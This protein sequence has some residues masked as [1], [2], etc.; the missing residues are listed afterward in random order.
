MSLRR[1]AAPTTGGR[2]TLAAFA[3]GAEA[4]RDRSG[5]GGV[6]RREVELGEV[7]EGGAMVRVVRERGVVVLLGK[8]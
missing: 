4:E 5:G 2:S 8:R 7:A 6:L 3:R 1:Y